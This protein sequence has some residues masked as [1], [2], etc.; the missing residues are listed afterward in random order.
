MKSLV[1][2]LKMALFLLIIILLIYGVI[3]AKNLLFPI[4]FGVLFA[5]L[6]LPVATFLESNGIPRILANL[7]VILLVLVVFGLI[8]FLFY[9]RMALMF[10]NLDSLKESANK[11]IESFQQ[12]I[13][14]LIGLSDNRFED[15]LKSQVNR[16]FSSEGSGIGQVFSSATGAVFSLLIL[17]VYV[18]LFLYY[19]TKFAYFIL[20]I[21]K[22]KDKP[23]AIKILRDI[24][25]V[26]ERYMGGVFIVVLILCIINSTGLLIIGVEYAI[27]LGIISAF[28]NFIPYF[29]TIMGGAVPLIFV[30]LADSDPLNTGLK[31]LILFI[32][33]QF[34]ENNI[35]TPNIV[36]GNV[37]I[38]PFFI[39]IGLVVG[40]M[41][42]GIPGMLVIVPFLAITR[43]IFTNIESLN[44]YAF[45]LG[46]GG[47][48]KHSINFKKIRNKFLHRKK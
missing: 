10:E 45:L 22:K 27:L 5:Y 4:T 20:N 24:S 42:W 29:G 48:Q 37:N 43:I 3:E 15:F 47:T 39:I 30:L 31:V 40:S 6:L 41:V 46:P 25:T 16:L 11:N 32:I 9:Q 18:F 44:H 14:S 38:N 17:P 1:P 28:F 35:L 26:A 2:S 36:G 7:M 23:V 19:R 8:F 33:I 34:I 12:K 13:Q 21:V